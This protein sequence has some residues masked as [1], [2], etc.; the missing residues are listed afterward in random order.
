MTQKIE[1]LLKSF[2]NS[3]F[4]EQIDKIKHVRHARTIERPAAAVRRVK[5]EAK[6]SSKAKDKTRDL[7]AKLTPEQKLA[8]LA[9]LQEKK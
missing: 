3:T 7:L 2:S 1:D 5:K 6:K 9:K 4:D 8:I